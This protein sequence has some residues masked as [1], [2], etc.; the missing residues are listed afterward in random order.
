MQPHSN[1]QLSAVGRPHYFTFQN[2]PHVNMPIIPFAQV[3]VHH[4]IHSDLAECFTEYKG[5]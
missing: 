3:L 1:R 2:L 4:C 5:K